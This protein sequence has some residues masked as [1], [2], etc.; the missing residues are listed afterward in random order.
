MYEIRRLRRWLIV[1]PCLLALGGAGCER[2]EQAA[3]P[4]T[5]PAVA[6]PNPAPER[7]ESRATDDEIALGASTATEDDKAAGAGEYDEDRTPAEEGGSLPGPLSDAERALFWGSEEDPAPR[8]LNTILS[9]N[10]GQHFLYSDE[11][12]L[13]KFHERIEGLGGGYAGV[14]TDQAWLFAAWQRAEFVWLSDY[15]PWVRALQRVYLVFFEE[16]GTPGEFLTLWDEE[17]E[18]SS[19]RLFAEAL[20]ERDDLQLIDHVFRAS[21]YWVH[22]RLLQIVEMGETRIPTFMTDQEQYDWLQALVVHQRARP[23]IANLLEDQ[24]YSGIGET[25][26]SLGVVLRHVYLSNAED[27]WPYTANYRENIGGLPFDGASVIS[28]TTASKPRNGDYLYQQQPAELFVR[29]LDAGTRSKRVMWPFQRVR[30]DEIP[31]IWFVDE[32]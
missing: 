7:V 26:R 17:H 32:P 27:Y 28:R 2:S 29:W 5:Q 3:E 13:D 11:L 30:H 18:E 12:H 23:M 22:R 15:D 20:S 31:Y 9:E 10:S 19:R 4:S 14:G 8:E 25:A 1:V 21:R 16:A 24:G 6:P